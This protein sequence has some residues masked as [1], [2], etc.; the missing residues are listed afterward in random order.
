[1][2]AEEESFYVLRFTSSLSGQLSVVSQEKTEE[3]EQASAS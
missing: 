2:S 3:G 1:M